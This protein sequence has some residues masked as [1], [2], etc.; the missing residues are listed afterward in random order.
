MSGVVVR[1]T[2]TPARSVNE[3]Q[4][5]IVSIR[6]AGR[7]DAS[8][9][10]G[11]RRLTDEEEVLMKE[12]FSYHPRAAKK[13]KGVLFT[14]VRP[15]AKSNNP[16]HLTFSVMRSEHDGEDIS[17]M[18]CLRRLAEVHAGRMPT[19]RISV[20]TP[21]FACRDTEYELSAGPT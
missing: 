21:Y 19:E 14:Q 12:I 18:S 15:S 10:N 8:D 2:E 9:G 4:S 16:T 11:P 1:A 6:E 13:L 3:L 5:H 20:Q 7:N 17:Y